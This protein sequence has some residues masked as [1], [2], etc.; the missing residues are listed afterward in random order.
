MPQNRQHHRKAKYPNKVAKPKSLA[1]VRIFL[2]RSAGSKIT[3]FPTAP[4]IVLFFLFS[5]FF[6]VD[7]TI[8]LVFLI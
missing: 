1:F 5:L 3:Y 4:F 7:A 8:Y 2:F 6:T